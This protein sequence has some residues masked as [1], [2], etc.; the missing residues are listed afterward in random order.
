MKVHK[1]ELL[2]SFKKPI[3]RLLPQNGFKRPI[4]GGI[5]SCTKLLVVAT[6]MGAGAKLTSHLINKGQTMGNRS[7]YILM[8]DFGPSLVWMDSIESSTSGRS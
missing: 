6:L 4:V 1:G 2:L 8:E 5:K 7:E 3:R